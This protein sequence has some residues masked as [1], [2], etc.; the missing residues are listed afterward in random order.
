MGIR[1]QKNSWRLFYLLPLLCFL[2]VFYNL[3]GI[4]HLNYSTRTAPNLNNESE[5]FSNFQ[6]IWNND[7]AQYST[8]II[9]NFTDIWI[10]SQIFYANYS[11]VRLPNL[12]CIV[13]SLSAGGTFAF[14]P[15][16]FLYNKYH[17]IWYSIKFLLSPYN[18]PFI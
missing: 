18:I 4:F 7:V 16:E 10:E 14:R 11:F 5:Y 17:Y 9:D 8:Y 6:W 12:T 13:R 2:T 3:H 15:T 1:N